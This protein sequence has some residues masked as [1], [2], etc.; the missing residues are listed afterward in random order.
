MED[1][2][3]FNIEN[4]KN[5]NKINALDQSLQLDVFDAGD[6][7]GNFEMDDD[8]DDSILL[9]ILQDK[10]NKSIEKENKK[11]SKLEQSFKFNGD[12]FVNKK[13]YNTFNLKFD[14]EVL[15]KKLTGFLLNAYKIISEKY[16]DII[17]EEDSNEI[18]KEKKDLLNLIDEILLENKNKN[19][20]ITFVLA[21]KDNIINDREFQLN[22]YAFHK[23]MKF[24]AL[25]TIKIGFKIKIKM[26]IR[27]GN[28]RMSVQ[29]C[30]IN[31]NKEQKV[32]IKTDFNCS[33][34]NN[35]LGNYGI[36]Y[37][38]C[39]D[40][41]KC[42]NRKKPKPFDDLL[43]YLKETNSIT[44]RKDFTGLWFGKFNR[45]R[46][47]S[48]YKCSFC[49]EFYQKKL[50][51]VRL[52][53]NSDIDPDHSCQFWICLDCYK[54]KCKNNYNELCPNC[55]NFFITFSKLRRIFRYYRWKA[56]QEK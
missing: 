51:I 2:I 12:S 39:G 24:N 34:I 13:K 32:I 4:D 8:E 55:G 11:I 5:N 49:K 50:N 19:C 7:V 10:I 46:N 20:I 27:S 3:S 25:L 6:I 42:N 23:I 35:I 38:T 40:C 28:T 41:M 31:Y 33:L 36:T 22:F 14:E 43:G 29:K 47:E 45:Y 16:Y 48:G 54:K 44:N 15:S 52:F 21:D 37:C 56:K 26:F 18:S 53:C 1:N 17:D 9:G 30:S